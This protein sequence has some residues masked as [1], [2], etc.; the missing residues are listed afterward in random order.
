MLLPLIILFWSVMKMNVNNSRPLVVK[1]I[2]RRQSADQVKSMLR[3][4]EYS[5]LLRKIE[6]C[7]FEQVSRF[8]NGSDLLNTV[9]S[10][11]KSQEHS[12]FILIR[13][14]L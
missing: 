11:L 5:T 1:Q 9:F 12:V 6:S 4:E 8:L 10:H 14:I 2:E 7:N 13:A 3:R